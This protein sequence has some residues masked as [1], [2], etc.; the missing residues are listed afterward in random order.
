MAVE[1]HVGVGVVAEGAERDDARLAPRGLRGRERVAVRDDG[2]V[3]GRH[4]LE[5]VALGAGVRVEA[6]RVA[7]EVVV[8]DVEQRVGPRVQGGHAL[9]L[10]ARDLEDEHVP[11]LVHDLGERGAEVA[12]D[13]DLLARRREDRARERGGGALAVGSADERDGRGDEARGELHLAD[14]LAPARLERVDRRERRDPGR[15]DREVRAGEDRVGVA[16]EHELRARASRAS[17]G[18]QAIPR[19]AAS[20]ATTRA[21]RARRRFAAATPLRPSP[22]TTAVLPRTSIALTEP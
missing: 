2:D 13:E 22:I 17:A 4:A 20:V 19:G 14:H 12:A 3:V 18:G 6:P 10:E 7:V 16:A 1:G 9:G 5:G 8:R 21:P 15:D 11:R